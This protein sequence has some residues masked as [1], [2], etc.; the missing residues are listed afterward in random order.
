VEFRCA[1]V[2]SPLDV[3]YQGEYHCVLVEDERLSPKN[4]VLAA[5]CV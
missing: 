3:H 2:L 5:R 1:D 4:T